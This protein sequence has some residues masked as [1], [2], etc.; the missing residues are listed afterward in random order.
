MALSQLNNDFYTR[1]AV[2][3]WLQASHFVIGQATHMTCCLNLGAVTYA[4][5]WQE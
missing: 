5:Q 1:S 4:A 3:D 2:R